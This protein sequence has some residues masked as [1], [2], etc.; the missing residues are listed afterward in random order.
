MG[1]LFDLVSFFVSHDYGQFNYTPIHKFILLALFLGVAAP[2]CFMD[3]LG[4]LQH[5]G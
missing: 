4:S 5:V 1:M 2:Y 3:D